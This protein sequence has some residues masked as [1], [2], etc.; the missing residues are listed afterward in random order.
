MK[1]IILATLLLVFGLSQMAFA[2]TTETKVVFSVTHAVSTEFKHDKNNYKA[3][4]DLLYSVNKAKVSKISTLD[5]LILSQ[6]YG[7][8]TVTI[9]L[10]QGEKAVAAQKVDVPENSSF[11][12]VVASWDLSDIEPGLY[13]FGVFLDEKPVG[14]Y[15]FE[16]E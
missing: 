2:E 7:A 14:L 11:L 8:K 6:N 5:S 9:A 13:L 3:K 4:G 1:K 16:I 12:H 15:A 10:I